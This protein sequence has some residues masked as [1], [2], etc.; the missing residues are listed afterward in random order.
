M[1]VVSEIGD[2]A[3]HIKVGDFVI[4][5]FFASDN[6]C[7]ICQ[8]GYQS[9]CIHAHPMGAE[10][11]QA[12]L[13][14]IP[15]AD[16]T[17]VPTPAMPEPDLIPSLRRRP[18]CWARAGSVLPQPRWGQGRRSLSSVTERSASLPWWPPSRWAQIGSSSSV[19]ISVASAS[20]GNT[21]PPT[22][23]PNM[24]TM[25]LPESRS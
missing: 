21:A 16:G 20:P 13:A 1:G 23:S 9:R 8:A 5:S 2:E 10:G 22:S 19:A 18:M 25:E 3:P 6:T 14:R 4:G 24:E 15:L 12:E 17:L 7:E 11:T